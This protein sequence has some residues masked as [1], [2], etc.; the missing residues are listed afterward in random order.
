MGLGVDLVPLTGARNLPRSAGPVG[1]SVSFQPSLPPLPPPGLCSSK[2]GCPLNGRSALPHS[3]GLCLTNASFPPCFWCSPVHL[4]KDQFQQSLTEASF[5]LQLKLFLSDATF[6][7]LLM[8]HGVPVRR[9][10]D[11]TVGCALPPHPQAR[12]ALGSHQAL[13]GC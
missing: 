2:N 13:L 7:C 5:S 6:T 8:A 9:D 11:R 12:V 4:W 10:G 1:L 3:H